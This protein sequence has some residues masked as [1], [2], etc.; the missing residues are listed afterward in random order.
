[1]T[2]EEKLKAEQLDELKARWEDDFAAYCDEPAFPTL[3]HVDAKGNPKQGYEPGLTRL[4]YFAAKTMAEFASLNN[5][6]AKMAVS[7]MES[8]YQVLRMLYIRE[9]GEFSAG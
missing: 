6:R 3:I 5:D 1:M 4:E 2:D 9:Y 7:A 8:A